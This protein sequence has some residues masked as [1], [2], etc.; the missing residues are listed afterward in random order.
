MIMPF[1]Y[2]ITY[3]LLRLLLPVVVFST[4]IAR[5]GEYTWTNNS[6]SWVQYNAVWNNAGNWQEAAFPNSAGDRAEFVFV[7]DTGALHLDLGEDITVGGIS[8][9]D[10][11]NNS[12]YLEGSHTLYFDNGTNTAVWER[13]RNVSSGNALRMEVPCNLH[14]ASDLEASWQVQRQIPVRGVISGPGRLT[15]TY[16]QQASDANTVEFGG[17]SPNTYTGGTVLNGDSGSAV[18]ETFKATKNSALGSGDVRLNPHATLQL[19]DRGDT[20]DMLDDSATVHLMRSGTAYARIQ[21]DAEVVETVGKLVLDGKEQF[22][23]TYGAEGSGAQII[24]N[25]YFSGAGILTVQTGPPGPGGISNGAGA[26]DITTEGAVLNGMLL[27]TN[28]S[29]TRVF[30]YWGE[31]D[32]GMIPEAWENEQALGERG[33]GTFSIQ[34]DGGR[35][36]QIFYYRCFMTNALGALWSSSSVQFKLHGPPE[37]K[38]ERVILRSDSAMLR[39]TVLA[40][41]GSPTAAWFYRGTTDGG[42]N[43][44]GWDT[45]QYAGQVTNGMIAVRDTNLTAHT[46]YYYRVYATNRYGHSWAPDTATFVMPG[47]PGSNEITFFCISDIHYGLTPEITAFAPSMVDRMN[48]LPGTAWP[49][50]WGTGVVQPPRGVV[51]NGDTSERGSE[52]E[53]AQFTRDYGLHGEARLAYPVYEGYGNHDGSAYV[54]DQMKNRTGMRKGL[55]RVS[56]NGMHYS[57]EWDYLHLIHLNVSPGL[58]YHPYDPRFSYIFLTNDLSVSVGDRDRPVIIFQHFGYDSNGSGWWPAQDRTNFFNAIA[59]YNVI[60]VVH[61]HSH[62]N[63]FYTREGVTICNTPH[64]N[65]DFSEP[66]SHGLLVF[67]ISSNTVRIAVR[68]SDNTWGSTLK[69]DIPVPEPGYAVYSLLAGIMYAKRKKRE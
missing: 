45:V 65:M 33:P 43:A 53:W 31:T 67:Q 54:V 62:D 12:V 49:A 58:T 16:R 44:G 23:G 10:N 9:I 3:L 5:G 30:M 55:T 47:E 22:P 38:N 42:T 6:P 14:L 8:M 17:S 35:P 46:R 20:D 48:E 28:Y 66:P 21:L 29:P 50:G 32:G 40:T 25:N 61:G 52:D 60:A 57:W 68:G 19:T 51:E 7:N 13:R 56:E 37:V 36:L 34:M 41:N 15:I 18:N 39:G 63:G 2:T 64:I 69:A 27:Y 11:A 1:Q 59:E 4:V 24:N 26:T